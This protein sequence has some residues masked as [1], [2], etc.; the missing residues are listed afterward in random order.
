MKLL[1]FAHHAEAQAF[2][3]YYNDSAEEC[4]QVD[5]LIC[6]EGK[7]QAL[8][9]T[10]HK[11]S[12]KQYDEV[13]NFGIVGSLRQ[14]LKKDQIIHVR[15]IY[16]HNGDRALY[17]S[18]DNTDG[19]YDCITVDSRAL[20]PQDKER[21]LPF[22]HII[23]REAWGIAK[24]C[25]Y[26]KVNFKAIKIISDDLNEKDFCQHVKD[27]AF[28][29][30]QLLLTE[31]LSLNNLK[32]APIEKSKINLPKEFYLTVSMNRQLYS[33]I[34]LYAHQLNSSFQEA[35]ETIDLSALKSQEVSNKQRSLLLLE[36]LKLLTNPIMSKVYSQT[37]TEIKGLKSQNIK[38]KFIQD[39]ESSHISLN[40][41]LTNKNHLERVINA[42]K[43]FDIEN[44]QSILRGEFDV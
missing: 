15:T 31:Y 8:L 14:E 9:T 34:D 11:L 30:S 4:E 16:A 25:D 17:N 7:E 19:D 32:A 43:T 33:L 39:M 42:L 20:S 18:F 3:N 38:V 12:L 41:E 44:V 24:A 21:Y 10:A 36:E 26:F 6:C 27:Q 23:D 2:T 1:V 29:F 28:H 22:A 5:I 40:V 13:Y 35:F 37:E